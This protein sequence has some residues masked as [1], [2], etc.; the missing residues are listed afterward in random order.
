[1]RTLLKILAWVIGF[2]VAA[3][4]AY[5]A[6]LIPESARTQALCEGI[7]A[8]EPAESVIERIRATADLRVRGLEEAS[9]QRKPA[10]CW[11]Y[12]NRFPHKAVAFCLVSQAEGR[13]TAA[14][15][16]ND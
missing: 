10:Q 16:V 13:I 8:G 15:L 1:M 4:A 6:I 7:R 12:S 2:P 11:F 14:S 5:M 9:G 3:I